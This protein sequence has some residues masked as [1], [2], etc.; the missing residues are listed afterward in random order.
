V[1]WISEDFVVK[2]LCIGKFLEKRIWKLDLVEMVDHVDWRELAQDAALRRG[3]FVT[4]PE[5]QFVRV[6][7]CELFHDTF[8]IK[9]T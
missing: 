8:S 6:F 5:L 7:C 2:N 1:F 9:P 3:V 4:R